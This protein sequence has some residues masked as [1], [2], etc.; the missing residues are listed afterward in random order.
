L[1][2]T[3]PDPHGPLY[4][5]GPAIMGSS[6]FACADVLAKVA[7]LAG[8]GLITMVAVRSVIGLALLWVWLGFSGWP[9]AIPRRAIWISLGCG[10]LFTGNVFFL[11]ESIKVVEVPVAVLTYFTYPLLTGLA[12]AATGLETMSWRGGIAALAAFLGLALMVGAHPAGFA[13][14]GI[15]AALL[16]ASFRVAMLLVTRAMLPGIDARLITWYS[17]SASTGLFGLIL[18]TTSAWQPPAQAIGWYAIVALGLVTTAGILGVFLAAVRLGPFRS[19]LFMNLEPLLATVLSAIFLGEVI[20]P[21]QALGAAVMI[22]ALVS[23]QLRR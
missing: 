21:V 15:V 9:V 10:A 16:A 18:V 22:G 4:R 5:I 6:A 17:L 2:V 7:L 12:A 19:A 11:F 8:S 14:W 23:F 3:S 13:I 1:F 20:S